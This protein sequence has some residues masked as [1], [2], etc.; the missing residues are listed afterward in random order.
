[1]S[2]W[3]AYLVLV[4]VGF[5]PNEIWRAVGLW[6]GA[7]LSEDSQILIWVRAVAGAT[8]AGVIAQLLLAPPGALVAVPL[9]LRLG[10]ILCGALVYFL[11]R[12]S[13]LIGTLSA[14]LVLMAG[15]YFAGI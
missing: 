2:G 15:K 5:L 3:Y 11:A 12:R 1:V 4:M 14:E 8:L 9:W 10:S 6:L 13:M 7:G